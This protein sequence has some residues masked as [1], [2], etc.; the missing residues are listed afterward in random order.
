LLFRG[1]GVVELDGEDK[2]DVE[3]LKWNFRARKPKRYVEPEPDVIELDEKEAGTSYKFVFNPSAN[4]TPDKRQATL[5]EDDSPFKLEKLDRWTP[6]PE[7]KE[8]SGHG[9]DEPPKKQFRDNFDLLFG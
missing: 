5:F 3:S 7:K 4:R 1:S 6:T 2:N 9:S 8:D